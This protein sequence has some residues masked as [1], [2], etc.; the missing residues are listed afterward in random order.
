MSAQELVLVEISAT[1][2]ATVST[3]ATDREL[4]RAVRKELADGRR[5]VLEE[6]TQ[7]DVKRRVEL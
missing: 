7:D 5:V 1:V 2:K 6:P 4:V 3:D